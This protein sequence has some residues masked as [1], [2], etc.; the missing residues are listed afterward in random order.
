M[1]T[2]RVLPFVLLALIVCNPGCLTYNHSDALAGWEHVP[3]GDWDKLKLAIQDDYVAYI[4]TLPWRE[5][6]TLGDD[7]II[8]LFKDSTGQHAI[9]LTTYVPGIF[10]DIL[11]DHILVYDAHNKRIKTIK[12]RSGRSMS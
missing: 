1:K 3:G 6:N 4:H 2:I 12:Y 10:S 9:R 5:Q 7:P 8:H 11:W